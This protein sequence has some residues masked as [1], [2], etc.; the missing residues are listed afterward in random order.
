LPA[1]SRSSPRVLEKHQIRKALHEQLAVFWEQN[2]RFAEI[3]NDLKGLQIPKRSRGHFEVDRPIVG[4]KNFFWRHPLCGYDFIPLVTHVHELHCHLDM[5]IYRR[6]ERGG[7]LF[8]GGDLDNR[9]K[10]FFDALS[11]PVH[12]EQVPKE[13]DTPAMDENAKDWP[14]LFCLL[15]DDKAIT[16]LAIQSLK[17]LTPVPAQCEHPENWVELDLDIDIRPA[18]P[19]QGSVHILFP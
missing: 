13:Q 19:M 12:P 6:L 14:P 10:T 17:M 18:T 8:E 16:R 9:L 5:R 11:V 7:I 15:D 4:V 1:A 2:P 3:R